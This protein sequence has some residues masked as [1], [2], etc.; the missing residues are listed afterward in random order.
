MK[1]K[2]ISLRDTR[3][4]FSFALRITLPN[5]DYNPRKSVAISKHKKDKIATELTPQERNRQR[6]KQYYETH[7]DKLKEHYEYVSRWKKRN[8][9]KV[10]GYYKIWFVKNGKEY[11]EQNKERMLKNQKD[12][13]YRN[14]KLQQEGYH[15]SKSGSNNVTL[16]GI[17][18][19]GNVTL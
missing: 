18:S 13:Y 8:P 3:G 12:Y 2:I 11:Y 4:N 19:R 7:P 15:I 5:K 10:K 14:R 9:D 6:I 17:K 16:K 1:K